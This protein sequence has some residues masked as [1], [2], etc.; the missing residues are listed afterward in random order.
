MFIIIA[1]TALAV[2]FCDL[3]VAGVVLDTRKSETS[4][5]VL[6][7]AVRALVILAIMTLCFGLVHF[8]KCGGFWSCT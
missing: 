6:Y 2:F 1:S 3:L 8:I 7:S 5:L 4:L